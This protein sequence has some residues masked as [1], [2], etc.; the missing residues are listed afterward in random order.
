[1]TTNTTKDTTQNT[2]PRKTRYR[3]ISNG[4]WEFLQYEVPVTNWFLRL[5]GIKTWGWRYVPRP[6]YPSSNF[7][8]K[9]HHVSSADL[10]INNCYDKDLSKFVEMYPDISDY[11]P[12]Y[13]SKMSEL[14]RQYRQNEMLVDE[15]E[16]EV[17]Y[18]N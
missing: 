17:R 3:T 15:S 2:S 6:Y 18:F 5:L 14:A 4:Q 10:Y 16:D 11:W 8:I 9:W 12:V 13:W 7:A 1:M